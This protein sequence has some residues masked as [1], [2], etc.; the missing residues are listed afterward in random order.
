MASHSLQANA[1]ILPPQKP[2]HATQDIADRIEDHPCFSPQ[3]H[4]HFARMHL[5]VA[6]ACNIQCH[7]CNRKYDCSNE[8]RP[9]VVSE[10]LKPEQA[11][12]KA[13][14]VAAAIPQMTVV[15]IAGPGDPLA[16]PSRTFATLDG[17]AKAAPDIRL[18]ISTNGLALPESVDA[19][20]RYNV[21]HVTITLNCL[22]PDIGAQ[23]YPWIIWNRQRVYGREASEILI[24][25][26][27]KGLDMLIERGILVKIN[28]VMI[29][30]INAEH[31]KEVSAYVRERGAFLHNI[32]PL[33]AK[34]EHGTFYG[35]HGQPEPS[36]QEL[37]ALR[38]A[39]AQDMNIMSH[40][41]QCRADAVGMLGEDRNEEFS[42][43]HIDAMPPLDYEQAK[44]K[45]ASVQQEIKQ[46][47]THTA[48][49]KPSSQNV[50]PLHRMQSVKLAKQQPGSKP[51]SCQSC[52]DI[53]NLTASDWIA[54]IPALSGAHLRPARIAIATLGD[55][56]VSEHFGKARDF[57]IYEAKADGIRMLERRE[58][59]QYCTGPLE[60]GDAQPAL[61]AIVKALHDCEAVLCAKIG[62]K[63]WGMLEAMGIQP[64]GEY[65]DQ[66]IEQAVIGVY[67]EL[68]SRVDATSHSDC[69]A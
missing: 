6:P 41:Q 46:Q 38:E 52:A 68:M 10:V 31:L 9:G 23:I 21:N 14:A 54:I 49:S 40:C 2:L 33:I 35:L 8:S 63:P 17:I 18:C 43:A 59:S 7:Y 36:E 19:L 48:Q 22:D 62:F 66:P 45:R 47:L 50:Y 11:V 56:K 15:G 5:A 44:R 58:V 1:H 4:R 3:A 37:G 30:N 51:A 65:E 64:S 42:L 24:A 53:K 39:C 60:C 69:V 27:L 12:K 32:M 20:S 57:L 28:S 34:P 67:R 13:L 29:P 55:G 26:Q 16:N 61:E 25:Q